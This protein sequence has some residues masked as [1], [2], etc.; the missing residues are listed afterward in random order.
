MGGAKGHGSF[1]NPK[2]KKPSVGGG[3]GLLLCVASTLKM[4]V[5][6]LVDQLAT[7]VRP[8]SPMFKPKITNF[9]IV[10][11]PNCPF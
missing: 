8:S 4:C 5:G 1:K 7:W 3:G 2:S 10:S 9:L 6:R 11:C